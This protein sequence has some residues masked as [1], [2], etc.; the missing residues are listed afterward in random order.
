MN[1]ETKGELINLINQLHEERCRINE[2][3][4]LIS[5]K[6]ERFKGVSDPKEGTTPD[7][8]KPNGLI[9]ELL[10]EINLLSN[11]R[12]ALELILKELSVVVG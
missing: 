9:G 8:L 7:M 1:E 5:E 12:K 4:I 11:D 2:L 10:H 3:Q 6:V